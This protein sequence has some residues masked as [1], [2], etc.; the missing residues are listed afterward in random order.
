TDSPNLQGEVDA[1]NLADRDRDV[2][3]RDV[4]ESRA[5]HLHVVRPRQ[6]V[7]QAVG[8]L[9]ARGRL[10]REVGFLVDDR[11]GSTGD[12]RPRRVLDNAHAATVQNL[13]GGG[14]GRDDEGQNDQPDNQMRAARTQRS[15]NWRHEVLLL[16]RAEKNRR[17]RAG[18]RMWTA[19][20]QG[21]AV[22]LEHGEDGP[23]KRDRPRSVSEKCEHAPSRPA[24]PA[25]N[26]RNSQDAPRKARLVT[27][28]RV[29][30]ARPYWAVSGEASL[31][32]PVEDRRRPIERGG[33]AGDLQ[34][35]LLSIAGL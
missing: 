4:A 29:P 24:P 13:R 18:W 3:P 30:T 7:D 12:E 23:V 22:T 20:Q 10:S 16:R 25:K 19:R 1:R 27:K 21:S 33:E 11:D 17:P 5:R 9:A 2:R 35:D 32:R 31:P 28:I 26:G 6:Q 14:N 34:S 8:T 15:T